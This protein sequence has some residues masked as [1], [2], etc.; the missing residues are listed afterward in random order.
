M[1]GVNR[2]HAKECITHSFT[3][4]CGECRPL[5]QFSWRGKVPANHRYYCYKCG[6]LMLV[7][8]RKEIN[9]EDQQSQRA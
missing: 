7:K 3:V 2:K 5:V 9:N 4:T 8:E 6:S 1:R